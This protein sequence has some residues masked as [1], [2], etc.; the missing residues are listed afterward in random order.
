MQ[1]VFLGEFPIWAFF[2]KREM[3]MSY[4]FIYSLDLHHFLKK[5][6]KKGKKEKKKICI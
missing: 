5:F 3:R 6:G 4:S 1:R 2:L